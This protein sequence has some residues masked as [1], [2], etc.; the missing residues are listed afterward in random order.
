[1][2]TWIALLWMILPEHSATPVTGTLDE[3]NES[4]ETYVYVKDVAEMLFTCHTTSSPWA[5]EENCL[6]ASE[7]GG[8]VLLLSS[9]LFLLWEYLEPSNDC[10]S[11]FEL[12]AGELSSPKAVV[13]LAWFY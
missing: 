9:G 6:L 2:G 13:F 10:V 4:Y 5:P 1:M 7:K 3:M 11:L 12:A 8:V